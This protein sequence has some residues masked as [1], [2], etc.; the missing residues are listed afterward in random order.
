MLS[1]ILTTK[2]RNC[3]CLLTTDDFFSRSSQFNLC[4]RDLVMTHCVKSTIFFCNK[5]EFLLLPKSSRGVY[6][7]TRRRRIEKCAGRTKGLDKQN[8]T[9]RYSSLFA[10]VFK[11]YSHKGIHFVFTYLGFINRVLCKSNFS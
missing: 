3:A 11:G 4:K 5:R 6:W 10:F 9:F 2:S 7:T 8:C 1:K